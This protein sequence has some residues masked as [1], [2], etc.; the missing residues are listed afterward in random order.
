MRRVLGVLL[1]GLALAGCTG[2]IFHPMAKHVLTPDQLGLAWRDVELTAAD[3]VRLHGWFLPASAP[4]QGSV[5]FL[6][7]NAENISTHIASV[8]W[9]PGAGFDVFLLDYRGYGRSGGEPDLDGLHL[10]LAAALDALFAMPEVDPDRVVVLGQSLG[11]ALAIT[12]LADSPHKDEVRALVVEGAFTGYRA[13]AREKLAELWLTWPLQWPLGLAID[14]RHRPIERIGELTPVPVLIIQGEADRIVPPH[15]GVALFDAAHEPKQLWLLPQTGHNQA[16][17]R[18]ENRVRLRDYL[19][20]ILT[21]ARPPPA[22]PRAPRRGPPH[23]APA[24]AAAD[25][26]PRS[27]GAPVR[28]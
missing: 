27:P 9:L 6:H 18:V 1:L 21:P 24:G 12:G 4:R 10:D 23:R 15:H 14:D 13:L 11:G 19:D 22:R 8:A 17:A 26:R 16:F 7:G 3:G 20:G 28:P 2:V 5:L 25:R